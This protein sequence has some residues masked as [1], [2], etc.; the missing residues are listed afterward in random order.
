LAGV[1]HALD[2]L[3]GDV[4][5]ELDHLERLA[6]AVEDR[7]VGSL[8]P[9]FPAA[10]ADPLVLRGLELTA[11]KLGPE[12]AVG[13]AVACRRLDEHAVM[14]ALDFLQRV[15]ERGEKIRIG[16]D[17]RSVEVELDHRLRFADGRRLCQRALQ[18]RPAWK[19]EHVGLRAGSVRKPLGGE[20]HSIRTSVTVANPGL[21][22]VKVFTARGLS[23]D[24]N[25][26]RVQ[27]RIERIKKGY[28][29]H[30][31]AQFVPTCRRIAIANVAHA[32]HRTRSVTGT[33]RSIDHAGVIRND[34][35]IDRESL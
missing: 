25:M 24:S 7:V 16:R 9:D 30:S 4:G 19:T 14:L 28:V 33:K 29:L 21:T 13:A 8:D 15:T 27:H 6:L 23:A 35:G 11:V 26:Q 3:R 17:D 32:A 22:T 5:G 2:F 10:L 34:A 1:F 31:A 20:R 18:F 12:F